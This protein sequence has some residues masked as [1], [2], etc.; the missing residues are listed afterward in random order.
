MVDCNDYDKESSKDVQNSTQNGVTHRYTNPSKPEAKLVI[1]VV[2]SEA[3]KY[4]FC[5]DLRMKDDSRRYNSISVNG[6]TPIVLDPKMT[7]AEADTY[8]DETQSTFMVGLSFDL[9]AGEN[10]IEITN[11]E[12]L[13]TVDYKV[14]MHWRKIYMV[15]AASTPDPDAELTKLV[16]S[17]TA[18]KPQTF[19][20]GLP[21]AY[22]AANAIKID[23]NTYDQTLSVG[24]K[25]ATYQNITHRYIDPATAGAKLVYKVTVTEAGTYDLCIDMRMKDDAHRW[26]SISVNGSTPVEMDF[27][28]ESTAAAEANRDATESAYMTG[29]QLE[30]KAG[31]NIIEITVAA[32]QASNTSHK[33]MHLRNFYLVKAKADA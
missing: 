9:V 26:N 6:S 30:L 16:I 31:E 7:P 2:V 14:T 28:M 33:T 21:A 8:R 3:G 27:K 17:S 18:G 11:P 5:L 4:D 20:N 13:N 23:C 32:S 29:Y 10:T 22:K 25:S 1:K 15:K 24:V 19:Y 12:V